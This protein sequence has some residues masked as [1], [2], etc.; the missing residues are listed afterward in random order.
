MLTGDE[1][2]EKW[3]NGENITCEDLGIHPN[4]LNCHT[5]I[6]CGFR[7]FYIDGINVYDIN[8]NPAS[9]KDMRKYN[10]YDYMRRR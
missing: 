1:L 10:L 2:F 9:E 3:V 4:L 5:T 8:G 6:E 7:T